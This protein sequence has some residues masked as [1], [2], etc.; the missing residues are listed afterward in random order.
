MARFQCRMIRIISGSFPPAGGRHPPSSSA[1]HFLRSSHVSRVGE[2]Q[3]EIPQH[4]PFC[5]FFEVSACSLL[6]SGASQSVHFCTPTFQT[7]P[8]GFGGGGSPGARNAM[9]RSG[10]SEYKGRQSGHFC[11]RCK[12][13]G[14]LGGHFH[15]SRSG[16]FRTFAQCSHGLILL[17]VGV[18]A[19]SAGVCGGGVAPLR[20]SSGL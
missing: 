14:P 17:L 10:K 19:G 3:R 9:A 1:V 18:F 16:T 11:L 12:W 2:S 7:W 15:W 4:R 5:S 20:R 8:C 13:G 6:I